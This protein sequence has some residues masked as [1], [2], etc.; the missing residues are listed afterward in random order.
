MF[1]K[2]QDKGR[3]HTEKNLKIVHD[4]FLQYQVNKSLVSPTGRYIR[5]TT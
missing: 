4:V 5:F 3:T 2:Y 1:M